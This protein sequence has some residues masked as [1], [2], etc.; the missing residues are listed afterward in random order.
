MLRTGRIGLSFMYNLLTGE[1]SENKNIE[2]DNLLT[3]IHRLQA[4]RKTLE[5]YG[6]LLSKVSQMLAYE[7]S[8]SSVFADCKP[9]SREKTKLYLKKYIKENNLDYE[10]DTEI[11][12]SGSI[13]QV[14]IGYLKNGE[15]LAVKVQ[16]EGLYDQTESDIEALSFLARFLY[17]FT[18]VREPVEDIG[19]KVYEE[20]DYS[21]EVKN[22]LLIKS[23]WEDNKDNKNIYIPKIYQ[24]LCTDKILVTEFIDGT[25][26]TTFISNSTQEERNSLGYNIVF[27]IFT[28]LF[29]HNI[30]YSDTH[31]GNVIV[32]KNKLCMI[33]FGCINYIEKEMMECFRSLYISLKNKDKDG[34]LKA[35][36]DLS[37][38]NETTSSFS[39]DYAYE[40]FLLQFTPWIVEEEFEFTSEWFKKFDHKNIKLISEWKLP[41]NMVYFNKI[42]YGL[43][44]ILTSLQASGSFYK[45]FNDIFDS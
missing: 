40:Y 38:I 28:N 35:L 3:N 30:F 27:F 5:Q 2:H 41:K 21:Q 32:Q 33:D 1:K 29:K 11:H 18:D 13:G 34:T 42:P 16:Y 17:V 8:N 10:I 6:G 37:I 39:K 22:H 19:K 9:F 31:Y 45:I 7:D 43:F 15:K 14:H 24:E 44:H 25:N 23:I 4:L 26:L 20:L 12:K 36:S